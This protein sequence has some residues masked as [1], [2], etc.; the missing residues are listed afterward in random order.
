MVE[1]RDLEIDPFGDREAV[2]DWCDGGTEFGTGILSHSL[3]SLSLSCSLG[4]VW[5]V[6]VKSTEGCQTLVE[7][8]GPH[9]LSLT[10]DDM[11][12]VKC[13]VTCSNANIFFLE[14]QC[15]GTWVFRSLKFGTYL[16]MLENEV[17]C[18]MKTPTK[19]SM[20]TPHLAIHP[21]VVLYHLE[22]KCYTRLLPAQ[23][24]LCTDSP[25]PHSNEFNFILHFEKGKYHLQTSDLRYLSLDD[26][27]LSK[28]S[29]MTAFSLHLRPGNMVS[30]HAAHQRVLYPHGRTGILTVGS[31]PPDLFQYFAL[32]KS[33]PWVSMKTASKNYLSVNYGE[34]IYARFDHLTRLSVFQFEATQKGEMVRLRSSDNQLLAQRGQSAVLADGKDVEGVTYFGMEWNQG[35]LAL[36]AANGLYLQVRPIG[37]VIASAQEPGVEQEFTVRLV[38]RPF[39]ILRG[40]HG[41]IGSSYRSDKLVCNNNMYDIIVL[42]PCSRG[43]YHFQ[44]KNGKFWSM[45]ENYNF[46]VSGENPLDFCVEIRGDNLLSVLAPNGNYLQSDQSGILSATDS[47]LSPDSLWEF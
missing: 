46:Y 5:D 39:L 26:Q 25:L 30:F 40:R 44:G 24:Q 6:K 22:T 31:N 3:C 29:K 42:I 4:Q 8:K 18:L 19:C 32:K 37:Q 45:G 23:H 17:T 11:G 9:G 35:K 10:T 14:T 21:H 27:L 28:R 15:N 36:Q 20:W 41:Y 12:Q 2:K 47:T 43:F 13:G 33:K 38:N 34:K 16:E 1:P 7:L